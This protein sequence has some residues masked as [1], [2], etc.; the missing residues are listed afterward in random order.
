[1]CVYS[2]VCGVDKKREERATIIKLQQKKRAA[3]NSALL[4]KVLYRGFVFLNYHKMHR[5]MNNSSSSS[6]MQGMGGSPLMVFKDLV[7][8]GGGHANI[9]VIKMLGMRPIPGVRVTLITKDLE[10]PYSGMIPA[11][12]SG[13]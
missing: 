7:L 11:Y 10:M 5:E 12:V 4:Q 3:L 2:S 1:M 8:I 13:V 6:L 9:H